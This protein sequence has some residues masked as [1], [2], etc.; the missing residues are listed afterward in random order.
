MATVLAVL[1]KGC[2]AESELHMMMGMNLLQRQQGQKHR[3][4]MSPSISTMKNSKVETEL[5]L[6]AD[7]QIEIKPSWAIKYNL[8][9]SLSVTS[10]FPIHMSTKPTSA[11]HLAHCPGWGTVPDTLVAD[12]C[13]P[14]SSLTLLLAVCTFCCS[15]K[16]TPLSLKNH[17]FCCL[18][19]PYSISREKIHNSL[20][21]VSNS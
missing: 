8:P 2:E 19:Y 1:I 15:A 10:C 3:S 12:H 13:P 5:C 6:P 17:S 9:L 7:A 18:V 21:I 4:L 20:L 16:H 14:T 11:R